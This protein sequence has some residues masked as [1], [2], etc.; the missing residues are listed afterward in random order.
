VNCQVNV[1][2]AVKSD[3]P[4]EGVAL[5]KISVFSEDE[6][7]LEFFG[8]GLSH[9]SRVVVEAPHISFVSC[10]EENWPGCGVPVLGINDVSDVESSR[11][12]AVGGVVQEGWEPIFSRGLGQ[13]SLLGQN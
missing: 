12:T 13:V 10:I 2:S 3:R 7:P 1:I 8:K 4:V 5:S 11:I 6:E 9:E